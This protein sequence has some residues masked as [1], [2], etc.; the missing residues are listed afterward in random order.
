MGGRTGVISSTEMALEKEGLSEDM[1]RTYPRR[2]HLISPAL[3]SERTVLQ[4]HWK[5]N[6]AAARAAL[7]NAPPTL[8]AELVETRV[9]IEL[10]DRHFAAAVALAQP[11]LDPLIYRKLEW[12]AAYA[13]LRLGRSKEAADL[14][15]RL[16][17]AHETKLAASPNSGFLHEDLA[18]NHAILGARAPALMHAHKAVTLLADDAF[19]APQAVET[20][21]LVYT[22]LGD[23]E[24]ALSLLPELL[25]KAYQTPLDISR[26]R[27]EPWWDP[28]R[29]DLRFEK[30]LVR[31]GAGSASRRLQVE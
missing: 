19:R 5:G 12:Y 16:I 24:Q 17:A 9:L 28:L 21:A 3:W 7:T 4:L 18:L 31:A 27:R 29:D 23:H 22:L 11:R 26:L 20:L 30:L 14:A 8:E 2:W 1:A 13:D 6:T 15:R 10:W 25:E